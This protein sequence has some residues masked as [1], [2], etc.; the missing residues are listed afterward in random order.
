MVTIVVQAGGESRRMGQD[1]GLISFLGEPLIAR[2]VARVRSIAEEVIITTNKPSNYEFMNLPLA[3]DLIPGRGALGGILTALNAANHSTVIIIA[4]DMPF[5]NPDLLAA[6]RDLLIETKSDLIVPHT[7]E[8]MEPLH[9]AY[10]RETCLPLVKAAIEAKKWRVDAWFNQANVTLM[11]KEK[12]LEYD[13]QL[14]SFSNVNTPA[15]LKAAEALAL[16]LMDQ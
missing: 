12:I 5:I 11:S 7:G 10:R 16:Q 6:Q 9:S 8:G 1:K 4:C 14:L 13:P 3:P 15:E 2:V